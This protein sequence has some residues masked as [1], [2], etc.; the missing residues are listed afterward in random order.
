M[1]RQNGTS[2]VNLAAWRLRS[3]PFVFWVATASLLLGLWPS[4]SLAQVDTYLV[5]RGGLS[6]TD[7]SQ[8]QTGAIESGASLQPLELTSGQNLIQL[9]RE[10]GLKWVKGQPLD[11][12]AEGQPRAWSNDGL[13]N[14]VDGP[15]RLVDGDASSSSEAI[16]KT[17]RNQAGATFFWD[18]G[19]PFPINRVRFFPDPNDPD[20]FIKAFELLIN[21]GEDFNEINRPAYQLLRRVESNRAQVADLVFSPLQGRFL[22][23][24]VLSKSVF[25]LAEFEIYG[26]GFVPIASYVSKLQSFGEAVN[27]GNLTI[28]SSRL[29]RSVAGEGKRPVATL[30]MRSGA[31]DTPLVYFR[32]DRDTGSV[33]EVSSSEYNAD[34]PRRALFRQDPNTK[35]VLEELTRVEYIELPAEEQGP[36][37]DFVKG[38]IREDGENWS[39]WS[40]PLEIDVSGTLVL[41]VDLP[42]PREFFQFRVLFNGDADAAMRIN[43]LGLEIAPALVSR[44]VGEVALASNLN[45]VDGVLAV[46]GGVDTSF[47]YDIRADFAQAGL[48]G[49][50]G[51]KLAAFP[52]PVFA[53]LQMGDPLT[54]VDDIVVE[55][56]ADGF[57]VFFAPVDQASNQPLR[58]EFKLRLLEHNTPVNAW[59]LGAEDVPPHPI[60][61]G[62]ASAD[63]GTGTINIYTLNTRPTVEAQLSTRVITPNGDGINESVEIAFVLAQFAGDIEVDI[64]V[65]D[66][67]GRLLRSLAAEMRSAGSYNEVWDGRAGSGDVVPPGTYICRLR[68]KADAE[69]I[70]IAKIIG[71]A[72]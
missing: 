28:D 65:F 29:I 34:L 30:Q 37:R 16:F 56:T 33:E 25:N 6:W 13:F 55:E 45:P 36:V 70:E 54:A 43:T 53:G 67:S 62:D 50:R 51:I 48:A 59:L 24:K 41:P 7:R 20:S 8:V 66:L 10:S 18:L 69:T 38:D 52:P 57:N 31:D 64:D 27:F 49:F 19:S 1:R 35:E 15:L 11:F 58:L 60:S 4:V 40:T 46:A 22:Q 26:E 17:I 9:L 32:R 21:D 14:Q 71:V 61:V 2:I 3:R 63:I 44:A 47:V 23:L 68:F 72:Y 42:S 39:P 5:G 12:V